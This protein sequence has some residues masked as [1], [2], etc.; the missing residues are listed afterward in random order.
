MK[1]KGGVDIQIHIFLTSTQLGGEW[2]PSRSGPLYLWR[3]NLMCE[4]YRRPSMHKNR[5]GR[6]EEEK[7]VDTT[8]TRT[9]IL[10]WPR[11]WLVAIS[12]IMGNTELNTRRKLKKTKC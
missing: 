10:Q 8:E 2:V 7:I 4:V 6:H 3:K 12:G 5:R 1:A 9:L 11:P